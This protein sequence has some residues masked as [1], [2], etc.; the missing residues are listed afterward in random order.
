MLLLRGSFLSRMVLLA[1]VISTADLKQHTTS[2]RCHISKSAEGLDVE[3]SVGHT[4][5]LSAGTQKQ[6]PG[7]WSLG[8]ACVV[9]HPPGAS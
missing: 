7:F 2:A 9:H 6:L 5:K 8:G 3:A 1:V 4:F